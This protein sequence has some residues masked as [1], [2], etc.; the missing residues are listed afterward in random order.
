[1]VLFNTG[2]HP[3]YHTE[4]DT[5]DRINYEKMERIVRLIYGTAATVANAPGRPAFVR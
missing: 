4:N 3:D 5:W 1:M 2:E